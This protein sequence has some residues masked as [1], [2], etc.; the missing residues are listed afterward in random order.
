VNISWGVL[1]NLQYWSLSANM[2]GL[3]AWQLYSMCF[4]FYCI[5]KGWTNSVYN[6]SGGGVEGEWWF[7]CIQL[8]ETT[9][10]ADVSVEVNFLYALPASQEWWYGPFLE[11]LKKESALAFFSSLAA[12]RWTLDLLNFLDWSEWT[13]FISWCNLAHWGWFCN[14]SFLSVIKDGVTWS[15]QLTL[16]HF[17]GTSLQVQIAE[18][19]GWL[20]RVQGLK[21]SNQSAAIITL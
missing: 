16:S 19:V 20:V 3:W 17:F 7:T 12:L 10:C 1:N 2:I 9:I 18:V 6:G 5:W 21:S 8:Q 13:F 4:F 15:V 14:V 11:I